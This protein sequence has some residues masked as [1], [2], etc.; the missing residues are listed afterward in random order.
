MVVDPEFDEDPVLD[1]D[2]LDE[3]LD[4]AV[5]AELRKRAEL[6][7]R[8]L[9]RLERGD[10]AA[11]EGADLSAELVEFVRGHNR[12][13]DRRPPGWPTAERAAEP[14]ETHSQQRRTASNSSR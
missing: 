3:E 11:L 1:R 14:P 7:L 2:A 10:P 13:D 6:G 5:L 9:V 8:D 4:D 12:L